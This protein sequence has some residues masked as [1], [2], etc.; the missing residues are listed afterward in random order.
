MEKRFLTSRSVFVNSCGVD[1]G[2]AVGFISVH[3]VLE[4]ETK[5][6][7]IENCEECVFFYD[8][9]LPLVVDDFV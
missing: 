4:E 6:K 3:G 5:E 2:F 1:V 9:L 8:D 7:T